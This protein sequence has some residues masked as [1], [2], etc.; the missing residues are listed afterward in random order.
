MAHIAR[1]I[2]TSN[3]KRLEVL[4]T[5]KEKKD[6][7][8]PSGNIF[9]V[10]TTSRI[11]NIFALFSAAMA[12]VA[13]QEGESIQKTAEKNAAG[14]T[15]RQYSSHYLQVF[16]LAVDRG[17]YPKSARAFFKLNTE[18]GTLPDMKTD[19]DAEQVGKD[20]ALG[21]AQ[22]VGHLMPAMANPTASEVAN[23]LATF[24]VQKVNQSNAAQVLD[25]AQEVVDSHIEEADKV[26]KKIY[27]EAETHYNEEE[28]ESQRNDCKW[29]GVLYISIGNETPVT[30]QLKQTGTDIPVP[31]YAVKLVEASGKVLVTPANGTVVFNTKVVNEAT[32]HIFADPEHTDGN[33]LKKVPII[34]TEDVPLTVVVE[35]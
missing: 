11:D 31:G 34:I 1:Y 3:P 17:I 13:A 7:P 24:M 22:L 19:A 25:A 33:P 4:T 5:A 8:P 30:V 16:N 2:P 29:W 26:I 10:A 9:S 15:L 32:L 27:D 21:E 14:A 23:R 6:N 20:I 35:V 28:P 18:T 12:D